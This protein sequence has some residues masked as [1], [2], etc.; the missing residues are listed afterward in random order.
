MG[1]EDQVVDIETD[2]GRDSPERRENYDYSDK[3][4]P[5]E[6][7]REHVGRDEGKYGRSR[8][9][10]EPDRRRREDDDYDSK[11]R[12]SAPTRAVSR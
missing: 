12:D 11:R 10:P 2:K 3:D 4:S 7:V 8:G 9:S 6:Q 5:K 1:K